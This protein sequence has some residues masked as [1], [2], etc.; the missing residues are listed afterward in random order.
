MKKLIIAALMLVGC[1]DSNPTDIKMHSEPTFNVVIDS[2]F[3][4]DELGEIEFAMEK[5]E[6]ASNGNVKFYTNGNGVNDVFI[7]KAIVKDNE[8]LSSMWIINGTPRFDTYARV[9][10]D[11]NFNQAITKTFGFVLNLDEDFSNIDDVMNR[12]PNKNADITKSDIE[13]MQSKWGF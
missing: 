6:Y 10:V 7:T 1:G 3:S 9:F 8:F 11:E 4:K 2:N 12:F 5:W 13:Q